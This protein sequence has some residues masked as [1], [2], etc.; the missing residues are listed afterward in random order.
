MG[1]VTPLASLS[2][3]WNRALASVMIVEDKSE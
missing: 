3:M 1:N 2:S